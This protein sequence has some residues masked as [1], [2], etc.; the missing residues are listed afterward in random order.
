MSH[1][2]PASIDAT[3]ELLA[4]QGYVSNR[5]LA[6]VTFLALK[7][8]RPLF[9]EGEAGTGKTEIAKALAAAL[10]RRLI[11]LQCYEGLDAASAVADWNFA[12]QMIAIRAAEASGGADRDALKAELFTEDYLIERPLLQAMRPQDGGPPVLLIDELD[13]TDEPFEAFLLEALSDFQVTIPELGTIRAPEP[14]I[15]ILTSNRTREVHDALKRRCL[16]HWVD[17]PSFER[18]YAILAARA[19]EAQ[20]A[21]SREIVAFVQRLRRE[22]LFKKPGVAE[23]IDWAKCLLALDVIQLSPEVIADTLGALLKYQDDIQKVQGSEARRLL[24]E[25]RRDLAPV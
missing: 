21:L 18:E 12:A 14:P 4:G 9:L 2:L 5:A 3:A 25:A 1:L 16:Y 22:D 17:Y 11:R 6:T 10:G 13:R 24:D 15:V 8:G 7:L 19:P 23:T 20:E